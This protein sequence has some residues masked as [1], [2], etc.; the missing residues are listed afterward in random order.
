VINL[1]KKRKEELIKKMEHRN[2]LLGPQVANNFGQQ[3]KGKT[4]VR[5]LGLLFL[6]T[7]EIYFGQF[8]PKKEFQI[9]ID[10]IFAVNTPKWHL[11][12]T[13]STPLLKIEFTNN[14]GESDSIAWQVK[15]LDLWVKTILNLINK[16]E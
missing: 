10:H 6:T 7:E 1:F 14:E 11:G 2:L 12:K 4:Q 15:D 13:K 16:A 5:G 9:L 3:S 8:I